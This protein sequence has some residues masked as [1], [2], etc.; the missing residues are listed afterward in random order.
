LINMIAS[1][2]IFGEF[3][4]KLL[5]K[6]ATQRCLNVMD[7]NDEY[8]PKADIVKILSEDI[9]DVGFSRM[10]H[11]IR[12]KELKSMGEI[13]AK[14]KN[15][16]RIQA[17][18]R[19][20]EKRIKEYSDDIGRDTFLKSVPSAIKKEIIHTLDLEVDES[21]DYN[22]A[23]LTEAEAI[24]QEYFFSTFSTEKLAKFALS[25][26]LDVDS[27]SQNVLVDCLMSLQSYKAPKKKPA[28]KPSKKKPEKIAKGI[29]KIDL[30]TY[31][32]KEE[33]VEYCKENK[34]PVT[35]NKRD[36]IAK[37]LAHVEGREIPL[38][39][40]TK[41]RRKKSSETDKKSKRKRETSSG[42]SSPKKK[43]SIK[44]KK[45]ASS[46]ESEKPK[47]KK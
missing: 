18:K 32:N 23:I 9:R 2:K 15:E 41:K 34:L 43:A 40:G 45:S 16:D 38:P 6:I 29:K 4:S 27:L 13:V 24:G 44:E 8:L 42:E 10:L 26:G 35:G 21:R 39:K 20:L 1:E 30:D 12:L 31:Y 22:D 36:L 3:D 5:R 33:L 47:K 25:C 28:P 46:S 19:V 14:N 37:I 7:E 17:I 11:A